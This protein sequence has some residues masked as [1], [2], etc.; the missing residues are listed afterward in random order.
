MPP[1]DENGFLGKEIEQWI[2]RIRNAHPSF[3]AL[4]GEVNKYCQSAMYTFEVHNKDKQE[5][6]VSTLYIRALNNYQAAIL[7]AER[8]LMP[9]SRV[10]VRAMIEALFSLCAIAKS[11]KYANEF[12]LEDQ[13]NRLRFLN[14]YRQ[15]HG[16]LP[17]DVN[18]EEVEALQQE[19][20]EDIKT[21]EIKKKS[22]EQ[23][24]IDAEMHDWYLTAYSVLS[25]SVHSKVKDLE[26]YL[27]LND[28]NE[29]TEFRWGPDDHDI[30]SILTTLIQGMLT[31]LN[32]TVSLF[33]QRRA[34]EIADFQARLNKLV[35]ERLINRE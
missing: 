15:L 13:R 14:K 10:L 32:C 8:G 18:R 6:L 19:L 31:A 2:Q 7:L 4:A 16:G 27:V 25:E 21:S 28:E 34:S 20:Q 35:E 29:I 24:S 33:E 26:R 9:Q 1:L 12:I 22:T 11:E 30:E 17:P 23:W 3:F 5:V